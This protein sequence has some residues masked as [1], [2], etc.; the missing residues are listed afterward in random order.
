MPVA[1]RTIARNLMN[2]HFRTEWLA[3]PAPVPTLFFDDVDA[4]TADGDESWAR[5][6]IRHAPGGQVT[7]G[8][9]GQ[10]RF[11]RNPPE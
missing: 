6:T 1:S 10:R 9:K 7:A 5:I 3:Q 11:R 2:N 8:K 4:P